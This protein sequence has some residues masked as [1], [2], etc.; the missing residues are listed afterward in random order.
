MQNDE[1]FGRIEWSEGKWKGK[2]SIPYLRA[3]GGRV[4]MSEEELKG[5]PP[6][7][8]ME[9]TIET[10]GEKRTKPTD[11]QKAAWK[12]I[13]ASGDAVWDRAMDALIAEYLLQRPRRA[14]YWKV[15]RGER[16]LD[17]KLPAEVDRELMK[18]LIWPLSCRVHAENKEH[19]T[20]DSFV[21]FMATWFTMINVYLR[22][23][24]VLEVMTMEAWLSRRGPWM[25]HPVFKT[26][27]RRLRGKTPWWGKINLEAF[28][29]YAAAIAVDRSCWD[30][31]YSHYDEPV[32][33]LPWD[34]A[35]GTT[36]ITVYPGDKQ[37][38][39]AQA[40]AFEEFVKNQQAYATKSIDLILKFYKAKR[41]AL[42]KEYDGET[43]SAMDR[44]FMVKK[45][46]RNASAAFPDLKEPED[47]KDWI[48][49]DNIHVFPE[50]GSKPVAIGLEFRAP[51][52]GN[53]ITNG[54][55]GLRWRDGK[56]EAIGR[57]KVAFPEGS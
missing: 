50:E 24:Q 10:A 55:I 1:V 25:E 23:G 29:P 27:R 57:G 30:T 33:T 14:R 26:L 37:P 47:L 41:E 40:A 2:V 38:T 9:L 16:D 20:V 54:N 43:L 36:G 53:A 31:S 52:A 42:R 49:L 28:Q 12:K 18:Q 19:G 7:G 48:E 56:L 17:E 4:P 21:T 5:M 44:C 34:V 11:A 3:C 32:S 51:W 45:E 13:T 22:D 46:R 8:T 35:R 6:M 39:P 15:V